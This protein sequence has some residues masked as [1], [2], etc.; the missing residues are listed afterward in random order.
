MIKKFLLPI[1]LTSS[2]MLSAQ[3]IQI[4][5]TEYDLPNGLHVILHEDHSTPIVAV[6]IMYHVGSKNENPNRTGFAHFFEHLLFEGSENIPRGEFAKIVERSGG[7]LNANTS[8]DR[9]YYFE[10]M[11]SNQLETSLWLESERLMHAKVDKVG[12]ETQ[13]SVVKEEKRQRVDNQPY[14]TLIEEIMKRMYTNHPYRWMTI[15]SMEHLD[16]ASEEDYVNFYKTFY[17]PNNAVLSIAGDINVE[18]TK[19]LIEKYFGP[20]PKGTKPIFRPTSGDVPLTSE[21]KDTVYDNIQ[22]PAVIE[23]YRMPSIKDEDFYAVRMLGQ[24]LSEGE[25]SKMH[26]AIVDE[27]QKAVFV[28]AFPY[29]LEHEGVFI[30]FGIAN[31]GG[32][33]GDLQKSMDEVIFSTQNDLI[34][35][36]DFT[37]L[38]NSIETE[39]VSRNATMAGIAETLA[40]AYTYFK[41]TSLVNTE[42][43]KYMKVTRE[44]I[45]RVANQYF[46][47]NKRVVLYYMPKLKKS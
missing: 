11:P 37:K 8:N 19:K 22:L 26:K 18:Q 33:P 38:R 13:R 9:T 28:G 12:I 10:I 15:G 21:I 17:V 31:F 43:D 25:S 36:N 45:K 6:S 3:S 14:G 32:D 29:P 4:K 7:T 5:Y 27:Q 20:I 24:Y 30:T 40:S 35:E 42:L 44:D 39:F 1:L 47:K 46:N 41:N 23:A 34:S 16:A 2:F